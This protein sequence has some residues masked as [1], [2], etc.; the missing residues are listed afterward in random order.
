LA[1]DK[2]LIECCV[3]SNYQTGA[4]KRGRPHPIFTFLEYGI[5]VAICTDNTTVSDTNQ[6]LENKRLRHRLSVS[7]LAVI[8][9]NALNYSFI[10]TD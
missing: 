2:I 8:H 3:S 9:Q 10:R 1:R 7:Q 6:T 4:V 5:P